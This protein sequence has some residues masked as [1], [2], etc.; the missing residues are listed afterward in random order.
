MRESWIVIKYK[1]IGFNFFLGMN[2]VDIFFVGNLKY[3]KDVNDLF[4]R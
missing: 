1:D 3:W 4:V 2:N